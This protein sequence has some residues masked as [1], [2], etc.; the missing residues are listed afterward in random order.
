MKPLHHTLGLFLLILTLALAWFGQSWTID[1]PPRLLDGWIL[2]LLASLLFASLSVWAQKDEIASPLKG[3]GVRLAHGVTASPS[4]VGLMVVGVVVGGLSFWLDTKPEYHP[5]PALL[6]WLA[7]S[8]LLLWGTFLFDKHRPPAGDDLPAVNVPLIRVEQEPVVKWEIIA[9]ITITIIGFLARYVMVD[10][11][12]YNL[13]GDEGEMGMAARRVMAG[14]LR[15]PFSTD[16]LSHPNIWFFM[17]SL[18]LCLFGDSVFGLRMLS[19]LFGTIAIPLLYMFVRSNYSRWTALI[20]AGL[21]A[22]FHFHI[23]YS[24][25]GLNN[26][27]DSFLALVGFTALLWGMQK[28]SFFLMALT[29][30]TLGVAQHLY[31]GARLLPLILIGFLIH[32]LLV[33]RAYLWS[34]RYHLG[35]VVIGFLLGFGPLLRHFILHPHEFNA[36]LVLV[37]IV[38]T[39]WLEQQLEQGTHLLPLLFEQARS[40]FGAFTF[41]ADRSAQYDPAI[42]ILDPI[43]SI[44]FVFGVAIAVIQWRRAG[45]IVSLGW[46][47]GATVFGGM[48]LVNPPMSPR[49][50]TTAPPLCLLM[51]LAITELGAIVK[52]ALS[53]SDHAVYGFMSAILVIFAVWNVNFYFN[54]YT[55]RNV[56]G[57][58]NT[59][60]GTEI[61]RYLAQKPDDIYVY[62]FGPP[63]MFFGFGAVRFLAPEIEGA[64]VHQPITSPNQLPPLPPG[65]KPIFI[66]LPERRDQLDIIRQRY[67]EGDLYEFPAQSM[68]DTTLFVSYEPDEYTQ[69]SLEEL[70][71]EKRMLE[72]TAGF[73][74]ANNGFADRCLTT[75]LRRH[76]I[77]RVL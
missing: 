19:V 30:V 74:P 70:R 52:K 40:A 58:L 31:M 65:K 9:I 53:L 29:G 7:G 28:R 46:I 71:G 24:R 15:D 64:D 72:A 41:V 20:A 61:G 3:I 39:G 18:S 1:F 44:F 42:P 35:V 75:W 66:A 63:R 10:V 48:L 14:E 2:L 23:H 27:A 34:L 25:N 16:W 54:V 76:R 59:E 73:E 11:I 26:I 55:P 33:N 45:A 17:Q 13:T 56:Y 49:Y 77:P 5:W 36:R 12:P 69:N 62:F 57:W 8:G 51:A 37:G 47:A 50:V 43:S 68:D 6:T 38:Q 4:G 60:V 22:T 67:P 21:L 32:Q